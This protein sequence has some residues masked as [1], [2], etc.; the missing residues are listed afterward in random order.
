[1]MAEGWLFGFITALVL[2]LVWRGF[3][4][5]VLSE[6]AV[7]WSEERARRA[8]ARADAVKAGYG[9]WRAAMKPAVTEGGQQ[10]G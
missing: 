4:E 2:M 10:D 6:R 8:R 5:L 1:M 7:R 9:A 3:Q